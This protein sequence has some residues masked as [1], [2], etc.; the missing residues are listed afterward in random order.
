MS[1]CPRSRWMGEGEGGRA[2]RANVRVELHVFL[3]SHTLRLARVH[4]DVVALRQLGPDVVE[5]P[6]VLLG[7]G[8]GGTS[9]RWFV[10]SGWGREVVVEDGVRAG[11]GR[12][13]ES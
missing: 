6:G 9:Y 2:D 7:H 10:L 1:E 11:A 3:I 4:H 8:D 13:R 5:V 12:S